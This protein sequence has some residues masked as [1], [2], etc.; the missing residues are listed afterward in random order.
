MCYNSVCRFID[1]GF[2][3]SISRVAYTD[4]VCVKII[5]SKLSNFYFMETVIAITSNKEIFYFILPM[6]EHFVY[7]KVIN[8]Q[9]DVQYVILCC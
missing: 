6:Q 3:S 4:Y 1:I 8:R 2:A 5:I 9:R 7:Q